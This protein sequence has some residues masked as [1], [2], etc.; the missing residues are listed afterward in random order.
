V[1]EYLRVFCHVGFFVALV[2]PDDRTEAK[3]MV[4]VSLTTTQRLDHLMTAAC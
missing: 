3:Q 2:F 4:E 1:A